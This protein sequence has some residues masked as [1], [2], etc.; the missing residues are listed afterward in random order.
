MVA[1]NLHCAWDWFVSLEQFILKQ[2]LNNFELLNLTDYFTRL[3]YF[4][5]SCLS[6]QCNTIVN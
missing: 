5:V 1:L 2:A 6:Q 3:Q 4:A